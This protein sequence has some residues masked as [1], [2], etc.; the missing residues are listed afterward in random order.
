MKREEVF[1]LLI[2]EGIGFAE[3][4]GAKPKGITKDEKGGG[5][6]S[7][8]V[9]REEDSSLSDKVGWRGLAKQDESSILRQW[10]HLFLTQSKGRALSIYLLRK[11]KIMKR[12][13]NDRRRKIM[14]KNSSTQGGKFERNWQSVVT[15]LV[16]VGIILLTYNQ[17]LRLPPSAF[18]TEVGIVMQQMINRSTPLATSNASRAIAKSI[19]KNHSGTEVSRLVEAAKIASTISVR[20][21]P[22]K[23][24]YAEEL[25]GIFVRL[26]RNLSVGT[27]ASMALAMPPGAAWVRVPINPHDNPEAWEIHISRMGGNFKRVLEHDLTYSDYVFSPELKSRCRRFVDMEIA[28]IDQRPFSNPSQRAVYSNQNLAWDIEEEAQML[29]VEVF[30]QRVPTPTTLT[31]LTIRRIW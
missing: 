22:F 25:A 21:E 15:K 27:P 26:Y 6:F 2:T 30:G 20:M 1:S 28:F 24:A 23:K 11:R 18:R 3:A 4:E 12:H 9:C 10:A 31:T 5:F 14:E 7:S 19:A 17:R 29:H 16:Y 8:R 13:L